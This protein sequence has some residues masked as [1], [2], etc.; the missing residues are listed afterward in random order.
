MKRKI[1]GIGIFMLLITTILPLTA[2]E[3]IENKNV[4]N[5]AS[6]IRYAGG[7]EKTFGGSGKDAGDSIWQT[8]DGGY[9]IVGETTSYGAG[10]RDIWLIKTDAEGNIE[11]DTTFGGTN[12]DRGK[13]GQQTSD[14]G[15]IIIGYTASFGAGGL[16]AWLIKTDGEGNKQWN[17]TF[18]GNGDEEGISVQQTSDGGY[19][20]GA[21]TNSYGAGDIDAWLIKTDSN[22]NE[23]WNIT[24][25][26]E[27]VD[28]CEFAR[29]TSDGG[30]IFIG[31]KDIFDPDDLYSDVL[32]V[33]TDAYGT[34]EWE[35]IFNKGKMDMGHSVQQT[36]DGGYILTGW[37][38]AGLFGGGDVWLMKTDADGN[39]TWENTIGKKLSSDAA[40]WVEQTLDGGYILTGCTGFLIMGLADWAIPG[41]PLLDK[42]L[43]IKTDDMGNL[44]WQTKCG[45]G[46]CMGRSIKP[47]THGGY[48][49]VGNTGNH[50]NTKDVLLVKL[51]ANGNY[52]N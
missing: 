43:V 8:I 52:S 3:S 2:V 33:K 42:T 4:N 24:V 40:L 45:P 5:H 25:G 35:K 36:S 41:V 51:D 29:Q 48:I 46:I 23:T 26:G 7:W 30:F 9:I 13:M 28:G 10:D 16:D 47:T 44:E 11:W 1:I 49:V 38:D 32:L 14:E 31:Y 20:L 34:I 6:S 21:T 15:Y 22:G 18:G 12:Y 19:I 17:K 50:H 37:I 39:E 27:Y